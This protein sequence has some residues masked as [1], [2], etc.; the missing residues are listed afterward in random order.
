MSPEPAEKYV[1]GV[2]LVP[3]EGIGEMDAWHG[4]WMADIV[5]RIAPEAKVIP[6][7]IRPSCQ[8]QD[9]SKCDPQAYEEYLIEGIRYAADHGAVA[10]TCSS[11]PV[12]ITP[13]L[14][15][16][17][18]YVL[19]KGTLFVNVHPEYVD[20]RDQRFVFCRGEECVPD[21]F[22][23]G[24]VSV[25]GHEVSPREERDL[26]VWPY[27]PDPVFRDG[28]GFSN[29][30][31]TIGGV[32]AL[33]KSVNQNLGSAEIKQIMIETARIEDGFAIL[34]AEAAVKEALDRK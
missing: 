4:E 17:I 18:A 19:G 24:I 27:A 10:V 32:V 20:Y 23:A 28:W 5:H 11:G 2:S 26:Y 15:D 8:E 13:E 22:H 33:M 6:I 16:A 34:D 14:R 7:R 9:R 1:D 29:G 25:P 21:V 30:P 3:G 31:P 12:K